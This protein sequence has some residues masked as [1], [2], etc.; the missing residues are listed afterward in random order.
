MNK[1]YIVVHKNEPLIS[2]ENKMSAHRWAEIKFGSATDGVVVKDVY[3]KA[4]ELIQADSPKN[5]T[6]A[7]QSV[8]PPFR[9]G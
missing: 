5:D 1:I 2:F 6:E 3:V 8:F 9:V 7:P 4:L